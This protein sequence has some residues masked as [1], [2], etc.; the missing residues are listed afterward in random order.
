MGYKQFGRSGLFVSEIALGTMT[1]GGAADAGWWQAIGMPKQ[2]Q[3]DGVV[4][5][6]L[7]AGSTSSRARTGCRSHSHLPRSTGA[8]QQRRTAMLPR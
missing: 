7:E 3:V 4:G 1:F 2:D 5:R 6:A 8:Y